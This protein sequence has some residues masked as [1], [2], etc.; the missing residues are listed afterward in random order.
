MIQLQYKILYGLYSYSYHMIRFNM[1]ILSVYTRI[2]V[3][4]TGLDVKFKPTLSPKEYHAVIVLYGKFT[5]ILRKRK[6]KN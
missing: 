2:S 4:D 6:I 5:E 3:T 1:H